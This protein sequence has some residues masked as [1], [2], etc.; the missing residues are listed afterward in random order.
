MSTGKAKLLLISV[1]AVRGTSFLFS[2][3]LL[4]SMSPMSVM[5]VRFVLAF[6]VLA[7]IF[8][9]K[10]RHSSKASIRGGVLLGVLYTVCMIFEMYGLRLVDT[11]VA[12]LIENMAIVLVPIYA[13]I[14]TGVPPAKKTMICALLSVVGVGFLSAAQGTLGGSGLGILFAIL[15]AMTYGICI[16]ITE[17]VSR[18]GDPITI[19]MIQLGT[20]GIL[21]L[22]TALAAGSFELPQ[23][24]NQWT[25]MLVLVLACSC[26]GFAFQPVGQKH[27]PAET[28]A[29]FTVVNPMTACIIG[30]TLAGEELNPAKIAGIILIM[31]ALLLYNT[32]S[33]RKKKKLQT[34]GA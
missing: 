28:A 24:G 6:L 2:K 15:S 7:V 8:F 22:I 20:M 25:M 9:P 4:Q 3:S 17:K 21:S 31:T 16:L 10:L 32:S 11:G 29:V 30:V 14:L 19:G 5:A 23:T 12:A 26:F 34:I 1:F 13:A 18:E 27:V 33:A